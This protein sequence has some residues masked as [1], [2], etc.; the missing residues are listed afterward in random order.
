MKV[1]ETRRRKWLNRTQPKSRTVC[2]FPRSENVLVS[3][4]VFIFEKLKF[5]RNCVDRTQH[6]FFSLQRI[7]ILSCLILLLHIH[8]NF[9]PSHSTNNSIFSFKLRCEL[10]DLKKIQFLVNVYRFCC[11]YLFKRNEQANAIAAAVAA[12]HH[13]YTQEIRILYNICVCV[14]AWRELI[15]KIVLERKLSRRQ[16][17]SIACAH[18]WHRCEEKNLLSTK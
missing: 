15:I 5:D 11:W 2:H 7:R 1:V 13:T 10:V 18:C 8:G 3:F 16:W 4:H 6:N 14:C 9:P 12:T 17:P